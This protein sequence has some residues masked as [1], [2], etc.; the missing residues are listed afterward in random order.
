MDSTAR[1]RVR[2]PF[3]ARFAR[4][5]GWRVH[6]IDEGVGDPVLLLHGNP[7]LGL[8]CRDAV[9]PLANAGH[10][11]VVPDMVGFGRSEQPFRGQAHSLDGPVANLAGLVR[12]PDVRPLTAVGDDG[13]PS[14]LGLAMSNPDRVPAL[15]VMS[16]WAW[17]TPSDNGVIR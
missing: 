14:G 7:T 3:A 6:D 1:C 12:Q 13:G 2:W 17:P 15:F 9:A 8:P 5:D 4:V 16:T 11:V 10:R